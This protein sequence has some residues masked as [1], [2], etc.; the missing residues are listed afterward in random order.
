MSNTPCYGCQDRTVDCHG[1]CESYNSCSKEHNAKRMAAYKAK[2]SQ[3]ILCE[4]I[5]DKAIK[6]QRG[7]RK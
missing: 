1:K 3:R 2:E 4:Y 5:R 7:R 6:R